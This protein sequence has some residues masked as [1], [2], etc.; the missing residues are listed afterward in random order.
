MVFSLYIYQFEIKKNMERKILS[1]S[2]P[3]SLSY[4]STHSI[5]RYFFS[6]LSKIEIYPYLFHLSFSLSTI[7]VPSLF[8]FPLPSSPLFIPLTLISLYNVPHNLLPPSAVQAY[9]KTYLKVNVP[10]NLL[11]H[12]WTSY[13]YKYLRSYQQIID[14]RL[15]IH[16]LE[17]SHTFPG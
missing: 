3:P 7:H 1:L 17:S 14:I 10:R 4:P 15:N 11:P 8:S 12:T 9:N 5:T 16:L 2:L 13:L 6:S